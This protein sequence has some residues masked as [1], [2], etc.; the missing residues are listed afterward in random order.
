ML[1][2]YDR[3][4]ATCSRLQEEVDGDTSTT[5]VLHNIQRHNVRVMIVLVARALFTSTPCLREMHAAAETGVPLVTLCVEKVDFSPDARPWE[6]QIKDDPKLATM[7]DA[8]I[9][10]LRC[11]AIDGETGTTKVEGSSGIDALVSR[12]RGHLKEEEAEESGAQA[13]ASSSAAARL[14]PPLPDARQACSLLYDD[15][16]EEA[17]HLEDGGAAAAEAVVAAAPA[18]PP[19]E[20]Y[21]HMVSKREGMIVDVRLMV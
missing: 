7:R 9:G 16:D 12:V 2:L 21:A 19:P 14:F 11:A 1:G 8:V 13:V 20:V 10:A 15:G 17:K 3:G 18:P 4:I 6:A 5:S